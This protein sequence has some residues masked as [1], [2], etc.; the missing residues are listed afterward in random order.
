MLFIVYHVIFLAKDQVDVQVQMSLFLVLRFVDKEGFIQ[1][2]FFGLA[3][4]NDTTSLTLKQKVYDILSLHNLDVSNIR[5]QR[6]DGASNIRGEWNG[7]QALFMKDCPFEYY[8]HCFAH[9]LQLALVTASRE[10]KPIHQFFDKLTLIV[11]VVFSSTKRHDELQASQ[12]D[13]IEHL[14][15]IG[16]IV[17]GKGENQ[18]GTLRRAGDTRWGSHLSSIS[19]LIAMYEATCTVSKK[20]AKEGLSYASHGDADS[21]Y[22]YLKSFDFIFILH[23]MKEIIGVTNML[24]QALQQQSQDVVNVMNLVCAIKT[25]IQELKEDGWDKLFSYVKSFCEKHDIEIPE[26]DDVHSTTRF[27]RSRL[28]ENKVTIEHYFRVEIF[29]TTIDKQLQE[30]NS[31]FSEQAIGL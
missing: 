1:E 24:C 11:N 29:F 3:R 19:S 5:G 12:L 21:A 23:L 4:V 31:R 18:I 7:L 2:R 22:N 15:E 13:E 6:Y 17:T 16:E 26:L 28:E 25:L 30:L 9:R 20:F 10:V 14:L 27:G 8:V